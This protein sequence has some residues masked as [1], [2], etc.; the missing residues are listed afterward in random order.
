M[1]DGQGARLN[2]LLRIIGY[3]IS[4]VIVW[5]Y[6]TKWILSFLPLPKTAGKIIES[7]IC[8]GILWPIIALLIINGSYHLYTWVSM[9]KSKSIFD[10][11][12]EKNG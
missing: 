5:F 10:F 4:G 1:D 8:I 2:K 9:G 7:Y 11:L 12:E 3:I 6:G